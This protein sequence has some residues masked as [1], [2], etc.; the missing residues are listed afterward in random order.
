M[1]PEYWKP[2]KPTRLKKCDEF[3]VGNCNTPTDGCCA[4]VACMYCLEFV[5]YS[6]DTEYGRASFVTSGWEGTIAGAVFTAYWEVG[7]ES[8]ECEFVVLLDDYEVYRKSCYEGQNCRDSSDFA[9]VTLGYD[10]GVLTW[11]KKEAR[12]LEYVID[13]ETGCRTWFCGTCECSCTCLCVVV[14]D[15]YGIVQARGEICDIAYP[16][17]GPVWEGT[18]GDYEL[19]IALGRGGYGY[20]TDTCVIFPTVNGYAQTEATATGCGSMSASIEL[21]DGTTIAFTC[22]VCDCSII[23]PVP[24]LCIV[25]PGVIW[26]GYLTSGTVCSSTVAAKVADAVIPTTNMAWNEN[27]C[28]HGQSMRHLKNPFLGCMDPDN[29]KRVIW[30]QKRTDEDT[31]YIDNDIVQKWDWYIV[32]YANGVDT[33]LSIHYEYEMC[34]VGANMLTTENTFLIWVKVFDVVLGPGTYDMVLYNPVNAAEHGNCGFE[35][36][37]CVFVT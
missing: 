18:V 1:G 37:E 12:P 31:P 17:D 19:S 28:V 25:E 4:V 9:D 6:G 24:C 14:T 11:T 27:D 7:Y 2:D 16:C 33:I 26:C 29:V 22:K 3:V 10:E 20:S 23:P 21:D 13:S 15:G 30:V 32:V 34:C 5:P 8:G 35:E 36:P